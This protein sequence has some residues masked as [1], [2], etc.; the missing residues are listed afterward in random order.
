[1]HWANDSPGPIQ[2]RLR[3]WGRDSRQGPILAETPCPDSPPSSVISLEAFWQGL[4]P[5]G[6][7]IG[8]GLRWLSKKKPPPEERLF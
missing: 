3:A 2:P 8:Q 1:M 4:V 5:E 7:F 6:F